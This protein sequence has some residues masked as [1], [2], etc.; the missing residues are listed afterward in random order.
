MVRKKRVVVWLI[1]AGVSLAAPCLLAPARHAHAQQAS[2][3]RDQARA[4]FDEALAL[5]AAGDYNRALEKLQQAASYKRTPHIRYNIALCYEKLNRLVQALGEYRIALAD[6]EAD[7]NGAKVAK[8]IRR[9]IDALEPRIPSIVI[10]RGDNAIGATITIDGK[11]VDAAEMAQGAIVD[12][13][14]RVVE[15]QAPGFEPFRREVRVSEGAQE[16][17]EVSLKPRTRVAPP[18]AT[19]SPDE[20]PGPSAEPPPAPEPS[21]TSATATAGWIVT[22]L[23]VVSLGASGYFYTRRSKA[24]SDLESVCGADKSSCPASARDKYDQGKT[25]TLIA[26]TTLGVGSAALLTGVILII[27]GSAS[28]SEPSGSGTWV[29]RSVRVTPAPAGAWAG[30]GLD[31]RF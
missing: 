15:A 5:E 23:G 7:A 19:T 22:G 30:L 29:S 6:A 1:A 13:G 31:G 14:T 25:D 26:N 24:I 3:T 28:S 16:K 10:T 8:E 17:I 9:A 20:K 27:S 11:D 4:L 2:I 12:P 21:G 18:V